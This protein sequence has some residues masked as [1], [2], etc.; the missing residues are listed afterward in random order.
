GT[1]DVG[2]RG[3]VPILF[4]VRPAIPVKLTILDV[5]GKATTGRFTFRQEI[6]TG[7]NKI[8][9]VY[10]PKSKR[11]A[12]DFFFQEQVYRRSG[13]TVLLPPAELKMIYGRG[14][15]YRLREQSITVSEAKPMEIK[16]QLERWINPADYGFY[17]GDHHI[18]A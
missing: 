9:R 17:S 4:D 15:E 12:P 6:D 13:Q 7:K 11:L 18:H 3:E 1:Q 14:P 10:P 16:V 8:V 2:F 5:D